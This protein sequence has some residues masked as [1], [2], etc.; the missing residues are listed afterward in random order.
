M[1]GW[2]QLGFCDPE[3]ANKPL[4][5]RESIRVAER[6]DRGRLGYFAIGSR[7]LKDRCERPSSQSPMI[8]ASLA[9]CLT[10]VS[11]VAAQIPGK[12]APNSYSAAYL[13]TKKKKW[14]THSTLANHRHADDKDFD[15]R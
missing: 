3:I 13:W 8:P 15:I 7:D 12:A 14:D 5:G 4:H 1:T 6:V 11:R 9:P 2:L 10:L